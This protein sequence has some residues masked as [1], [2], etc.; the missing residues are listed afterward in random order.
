MARLAAELVGIVGRLCSEVALAGRLDQAVP[1]LRLLRARGP[2]SLEV[3]ALL[4]KAAR[5]LV[6]HRI[7]YRGFEI[8][9]K[10]VVGYGLDYQQ[11]HRTLPYVAALRL[12]P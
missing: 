5:R 6:D 11:R 2:A 1:L 4:D 12:A 3:C 10:F 8:P 7:A 9:A